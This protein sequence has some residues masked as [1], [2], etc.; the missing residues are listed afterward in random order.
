MDSS[1]EFNEVQKV[2]LEHIWQ[3]FSLHAHQRM[4]SV[5]YFIVVAAFLFG[6]YIHAFNAEKPPLALGISFLGGFISFIFFRLENRVRNL[7][8]AS[9]EALI[10][11][12]KKLAELTNIPS[13]NLLSLVRSPLPKSWKYSKVFRFLYGSVGGAFLL[14]TLYSIWELTINKPIFAPAFYLT[15]QLLIGLFL[16]I[17]GFELLC[18]KNSDKTNSKQD[19]IQNIIF[20]LL[21]T[22]ILL[23]AVFIF[24]HLIFW[25]LPSSIQHIQQR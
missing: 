14:G 16:G 19:K 21:G 3:W 22:I 25:Q 5:Y 4:Q 24:I 12:E 23:I 17:L 10:P 6:A 20:L 18:T 13:I 11:L 8:H 9:E 1:S 15:I 2:S 7:I